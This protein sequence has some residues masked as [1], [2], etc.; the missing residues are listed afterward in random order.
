MTL[1]VKITA[2]LLACIGLGF[3]P[4]RSPTPYAF[5][6][7]MW[8]PPMPTAADNPV[9]VEGVDLGRHLFYDP[10]LSSD[11]TFS[12]ANCHKQHYAFSDG[13]AVM[14]IGISG[15]PTVR[16]SP[17]LFNLAWYERMFW[18]GRAESI[19]AQALFPVRDRHEM[20]LPWPEAEQRIRNSAFY[21]KKFYA[22]FG[23]QP[24]DSMLIV[25]AIGQFE[26]TLISNRSRYDRALAGEI[27]LTEKERKGFVLLSDMTKGDCLHCHTTDGDALGTTGTFANNG[28]DSVVDPEMYID[29]GLG[30]HTG[31][32][33]DHGKFKIPSL[34]N[35]ML[36][37]PYMHD[38]RFATIEEVLDFYSEGVHNSVNVDSKM[39]SARHK[40]VHLTCEEKESII[41]FLHT[42]TDSAFVNDPRFSNPFEK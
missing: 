5:P 36:T 13:P 32:P 39:G 7:L 6:K 33:T 1:K 14:S 35:V 29:K 18:D 17:A 28:L 41:T 12:C 42:L 11:S 22:A 34:R 30:Q 24:I 2:L 23:D 15:F 10:I 40:G 20:G 38:G 26:R 8:F 19:E 16:N 21:R 27:I 25:K 37:A 4:L 9:T 3:Q 31:K